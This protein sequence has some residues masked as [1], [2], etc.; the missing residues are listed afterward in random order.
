MDD[1]EL[2]QIILEKYRKKD[3]S[4]LTHDFS[5]K[6]I[7]ID[8]PEKKQNF[9]LLRN[10]LCDKFCDKFPN[11]EKDKRCFEIWEWIKENTKQ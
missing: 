6:E 2:A 10:K 8:I 9:S 4:G 5:K 1:K 7:Y 3:I 11:E